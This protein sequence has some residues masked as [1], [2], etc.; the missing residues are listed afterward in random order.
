M[1]T[2]QNFFSER[3]MSLFLKNA[4]FQRLILILKTIKRSSFGSFEAFKTSCVDLCENDFDHFQHLQCFLH[5]SS[6]T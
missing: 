5:C 1:K 2:M 6:L 3:E 4:V